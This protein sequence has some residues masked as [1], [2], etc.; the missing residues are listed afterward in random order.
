MCACVRWCLA[1]AR[2]FAHSHAPDTPRVSRTCC[3][4]M[5]CEHGRVRVPADGT[6]SRASHC[7]TQSRRAV[8]RPAPPAEPVAPPPYPPSTCARSRLAVS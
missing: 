7:V 6:H 1:C 4:S 8:R 5:R 3:P 2:I